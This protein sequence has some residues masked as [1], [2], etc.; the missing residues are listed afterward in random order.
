MSEENFDRLKAWLHWKKK[1]ITTRQAAEV[2]DELLLVNDIDKVFEKIASLER[3]VKDYREGLEFIV[4]HQ[5]DSKIPACQ[6]M[7][8][9]A[10]ELL[11]KHK[12]EEI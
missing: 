9:K 3:E 11:S 12:G 4:T 7:A 10:I 6:M 1:Q 8:E 5:Y 2:E